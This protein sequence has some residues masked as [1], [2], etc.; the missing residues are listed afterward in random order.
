MGTVNICQPSRSF[1]CGKLFDNRFNFFFKRY[2]AFKLSIFSQDSFNVSSCICFDKYIF[3][4]FVIS[5]MF[6]IYWHEFIY[7]IPLSFHE[8]RIL[9]IALFLVLRL[10][11][12]NSLFPAPLLEVGVD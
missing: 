4:E 7:S 3:E 9:V 1:L 8:H 5:S 11:I 2:G 6:K 12:S 10:G